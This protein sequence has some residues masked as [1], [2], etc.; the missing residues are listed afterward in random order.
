MTKIKTIKA[1]EIL[2]SRGIPTVETTVLLEDGSFGTASVPSGSSTGEHEAWEL[3]D[4]DPERFFGK[5]V[6]LAVENVNK[7]IGEL[8]QEEMVTNQKSIDQKMIEAD[9]TKNK[10]NLGANAILS[11]SLAVAK[12][13][14]ESLDLPLYKY[15][16]ELYTLDGSWQ[17]GLGVTGDK[18]R[19]PKIMSVVIEAGKHSASNIEVQEFMIIPLE[20]TSYGEALEET[21]EVYHELAE[22]LKSKEKSVNVGLEGAYGP[23]LDSNH[24][25]IE[26]I[27]EAVKKAIQLRPKSFA[28]QGKDNIKIALDVAA[29]EF[30]KNEDGG[31]Y[32]LKSENI[33]LTTGQM[34]GL[35]SE[36]A[37]K[38]PI[39][40]IEDGLAQDDFEGWKNLTEKLGQDILIVGD[41]LTVTSAD[42][43]K[44][45]IDQ[46]IANALIIKPN[47]IGTLT[48]TF[49]TI[50]LAKEFGYKTII[51][52]RSGE[53]NET[54]IADLSVAVSSDFIK[55]GAPSRGERLAKYNRL[56]E[57][58]EGLHI[59]EQFP[60]SPST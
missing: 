44:E 57:I 12:A 13:A 9:G 41:D 46:K 31:R 3:R 51:S 23:G 17:E 15:L 43:L 60:I 30:F 40:S 22:I 54:F 36:W 45:C 56:L 42:R 58:E 24:E 53:T 6:L 2:D 59:N 16:H 4:N 7:K 47:Q 21:A 28:G 32:A 5:G 29:S 19:V 25:A 11:V 52:H 33:G 1:R 20:T 34:I 39:I 48:E 18:F 55:T 50:K 38:Y 27:L 49:E 37:E 8:L 10:K 35:L 26:Y 14:A